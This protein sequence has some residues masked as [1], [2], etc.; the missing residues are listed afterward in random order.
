[1]DNITHSLIGIVAAEAA[2]GTR[3]KERVPLWIASAL[4]NNLPDLDIFFTA[5]RRGD[6]LDYL[7]H[8]RGHTHTILL[9]PLQ[10]ALLLAVLWFSW[11][12]RSGISWK[13]VAALTFLGPLLHLFADSWNSYGVHPFWPFDN[14]WYYGDIVFIVEPWLWVIFLPLVWKSAESKTGKGLAL[15]LLAG[16]LGVAWWHQA[17]ATAVAAALSVAAVLWLA[18]QARL[19]DR[20]RLGLA[21][22]GC[23]LLFG[24]FSWAELGLRKSF[25][26][27]GVE[28]A[29]TP[30]PGNPFCWTVLTAG[31]Q[32]ESYRAS[33]WKASALPSLV[34]ASS[35]VPLISLEGNAEL[36]AVSPTESNPA[37]EPIGEFH[38]TRREFNEL[39]RLCRGRAFLRFARIPFWKK[40]KQDWLLGDLRFDRDRTHGFA[41]IIVP[42]ADGNCPHGEPPWIGRFFP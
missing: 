21:F 38:G 20:V 6:K 31:F 30:G 10:S 35:C 23:A 32:G 18:A 37:R 12:R 41:E 11:R 33:A 14:R 17:V 2:P 28:V 29:M 9:A 19:V 42:S 26:G 34:N 1:M 5:G 7:L 8:H 4:A 22:A 13:S 24:I 27:D 36:I 3:K 39:T 15:F 16:I 25:A 40:S